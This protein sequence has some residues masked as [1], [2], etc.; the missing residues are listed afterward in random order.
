M[1]ALFQPFKLKDITL[2]NRIAVPPMCTYSANDGLINDW[3]QVHYASLA[4]GG[5]GLVIV[6]ATAVSPEGRISPHCT[7]IWN[8]EQAQAFAKVAKSIKDAGSVPGIQI[9]HA[10]RK[11]SANIP[12]EGDDHIPE[13]DV[14]GW[15]TIAPSAEAFGANLP[16]QPQEMTLEDIARVRDDFVAAAR[17]ALDAGFEWLELHFAHGY[18]AQS[19]FSVH[20]NKRNDQYGGS[21]DNRSR[22]LLETLAAVRDVWPQ[23]L[24][25]TARFGVIEFDGRD[26]ETLQESIELTRRFKAAG[27]DMLSVSIGFSTPTANIPWAPAFMGPIAQ[28]VREQADLPVSSAWGFGTPELA[29]QAVAS[30]QLDLVMVGK[31]HLANPHWSYQAA[32]ELG[33]DRASWTLPTP[34]AHWLERY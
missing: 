14:R 16:K 21:F 31:A 20:S 17:R 33:I 9:A 6:E 4:R 19:F 2:R 1:S 18:L 12:W 26:E 32:R 7:G 10:G 11:A 28:Q 34:Y 25:L 15:Q 29:E 23:H 3:H 30:G 5:A 27:L 22:F 13:G 24:P 8:D